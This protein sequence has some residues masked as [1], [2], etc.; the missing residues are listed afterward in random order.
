MLR[1]LV[2]SRATETQVNKLM[3]SDCLTQM[4]IACTSQFLAS[5]LRTKSVNTS[6]QSPKGLSPTATSLYIRISRLLASG[7]GY[8]PGA[9]PA[10]TEHGPF[11]YAGLGVGVRYKRRAC[12]NGAWS[13]WSSPSIW[14]MGPEVRTAKRLYVKTSRLQPSYRDPSK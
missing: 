13:V 1:L 8:A 7:L 12:S 6:I 10:Q 3:Y 9:E 11:G 2:S 5:S 4:S 14:I